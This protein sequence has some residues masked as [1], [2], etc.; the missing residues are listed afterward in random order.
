M[1]MRKNSKGDFIAPIE[2]Q[3]SITPSLNE[4]K[5]DVITVLTGIKSC[6]I[7]F[8]SRDGE[9]FGLQNATE[10]LDIAGA[11]RAG[12]VTE[13]QFEITKKFFADCYDFLDYQPPAVETPDE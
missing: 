9:Q 13:E 6:S 10:T 1:E 4:D 8:D 11:I 5:S 3:V 7:G 12:V 2:F